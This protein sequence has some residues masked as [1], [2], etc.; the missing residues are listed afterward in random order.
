[1]F[2]LKDSMIPAPLLVGVELNPGPSPA[3]KKREQIVLLKKLGTMTK[4]VIADAVGV[5]PHTVQNTWKRFKQKRSLKNKAGQGRKRKLTTKQAKQVA[6]KAKKGKDSPELAREYYGKVG[7]IS[8]RTIRRTLRD[9]GLRYLVRRKLPILTVEQQK[10]RLA[11]AKKRLNYDWKYVLFTDEKTFQLGG[12]P[13]KSWQ[14][15]HERQ[16]D[17]VKRHAPK[18]HAWAGIG[19]HFKTKLYLF[20]Q[21]LDKDLM[22]KILKEHLPPPHVYDLPIRHRN[23]WIFVQDNDPKHRSKK[24]TNLLDE[25][26]P[27]RLLDFPSMSADFN[28]MEDIWSI[29]D[30][31]LQ[32]QTIKTMAQL[33]TALKKEWKRLDMQ[34]IRKS[35]ESM[36]RRLQEC[37]DLKGKRT[38]Y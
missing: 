27:D 6:K 5:D 3:E 12:T 10:L 29:L 9:Q 31:S 35:V 4:R 1:M 19:S 32:H 14:D 7:G 22:H 16:T 15:P 18:V 21:N 8:A 25:I 30:R 33:K 2:Y 13:H 11:F 17:E 23:K 24:V 20:H 38:F 36:P 37:I 28:P 26:A 34:L